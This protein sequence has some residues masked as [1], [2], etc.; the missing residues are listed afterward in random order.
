MTEDQIF[1]Q[2][3]LD[4][5][6]AIDCLLEEGVWQDDPACYLPD[7]VSQRAAEAAV[8]VIR[9]MCDHQNWLI[10]VGVHAPVPSVN[11]D[12]IC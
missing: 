5:A 3:K 1:E 12:P 7:T 8:A 4:L 9:G 6:A 2:L 11:E 10:T